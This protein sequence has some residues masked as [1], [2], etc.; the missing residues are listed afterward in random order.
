MKTQPLEDLRAWLDS[1][2]AAIVWQTHTTYGG[3]VRCYQLPRADRLVL[4]VVGSDGQSASLWRPDAAAC[5]VPRG[6]PT[7]VTS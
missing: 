6:N 2:H 4:L 1:Q 5:A 3:S 7:G